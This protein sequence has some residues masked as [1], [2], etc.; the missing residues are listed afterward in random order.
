[1]DAH[2]GLFILSQ[3]PGSMSQAE[4]NALFILSLLPAG[5]AHDVASLDS[6]LGERMLQAWRLRG[7]ALQKDDRYGSALQFTWAC[8]GPP[9]RCMH[10]LRDT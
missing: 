5:E 1:M 10:A 9:T 7:D 2:I 8:S 4:I 3:G 6:I